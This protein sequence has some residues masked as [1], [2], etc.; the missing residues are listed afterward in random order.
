MILRVREFHEPGKDDASPE[1]SRVML[2]SCKSTSTLHI[3]V[4][5]SRIACHCF[6][7]ACVDTLFNMNGRSDLPFIAAAGIEEKQDVKAYSWMESSSQIEHSS[8]CCMKISLQH[9]AG[10]RLYISLYGFRV[11]GPA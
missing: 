8:L 10:I 3:Y 4:A 7:D 2:C 11:S 5:W 1:Q 6:Q 9:T